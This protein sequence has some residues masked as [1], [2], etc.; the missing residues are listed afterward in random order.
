MDTRFK[1]NYELKRLSI[2]ILFCFTINI[3]IT[4]EENYGENR[5]DP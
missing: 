1:R 2:D 5:N 4:W 3:N